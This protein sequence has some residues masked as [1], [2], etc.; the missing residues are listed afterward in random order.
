MLE[1][2]STENDLWKLRMLSGRNLKIENWNSIAT[3]MH[4][5][6]MSRNSSGHGAIVAVSHESTILSILSAPFG[7]DEF[8]G[9]SL[10]LRNASA[11]I[12]KYGKK[13]KVL[14]FGMPVLTKE[15]LKKI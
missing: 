14:G 10:K 4:D 3:R 9:F 7:L 8:T 5:F 1:N 12:V 15:I 2:H 13:I 11:S 6:M